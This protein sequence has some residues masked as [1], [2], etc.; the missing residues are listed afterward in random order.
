MPGTQTPA[1]TGSPRRGGRQVQV[2][3][4]TP[5]LED[6]SNMPIPTHPLSPAPWDKGSVVDRRAC[7]LVSKYFAAEDTQVHVCLHTTALCTLGF[8]RV[9][10]PFPPSAGHC[11]PSITS[12]N[13]PSGPEIPPAVQISEWHHHKHQTG[14]FRSGGAECSVLALTPQKWGWGT[15]W[16]ETVTG[17]DGAVSLL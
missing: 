8:W 4:T 2:V 11:L 13:T 12:P 14:P 9:C 15:R 16:C 6:A 1:C 10:L 7:S 3:P 5:E 17:R